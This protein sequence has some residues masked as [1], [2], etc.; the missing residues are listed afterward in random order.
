MEL[1]LYIGSF[2]DEIDEAIAYAGPNNID[3]IDTILRYLKITELEPVVGEGEVANMSYDD[4][5]K[6]I[7]NDIKDIIINRIFGQQYD[8]L[9][10]KIDYTKT[11]VLR[12]GKVGITN[13]KDQLFLPRFLLNKVLGD[14]FIFIV[15]QG[16]LVT[17]SAHDASFSDDM[18]KSKM[19]ADQVIRLDDPKSKYGVY[20]IS[21]SDYPMKRQRTSQ[22]N[23][24][25]EIA[26]SDE[27]RNMRLPTFDEVV[28]KPEVE[29][30]EEEVHISHY[31]PK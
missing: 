10:D 5:S 29:E 22:V 7:F 21:F 18:L 23:V 26:K 11:V 3:N 15:R 16:K 20:V 24:D 9:K 17:V 2:Q 13:R 30:P 8:D 27:F 6:L 19:Q 12:T 14:E 28:G 25:Q 4:A 31:V 1:K